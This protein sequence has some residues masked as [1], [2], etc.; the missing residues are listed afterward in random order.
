MSMAGLT[1]GGNVWR[2]ATHGNKQ[3][4]NETRTKALRDTSVCDNLEAEPANWGGCLRRERAATPPLRQILHKA[5]LLK[6]QSCTCL[7]S[8][9]Q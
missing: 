8:S 4:H 2:H 5:T 9:K 3:G 6:R 7:D 1:R